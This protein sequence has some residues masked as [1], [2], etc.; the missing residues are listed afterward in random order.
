MATTYTVK[1]GDTLSEIAVRYGTTVSKLVELNNINDPDFIVIG[2]VLKLTGTASPVATNTTSK[3]TL[4][5]FGLQSNTDRTVY[6]TWT[7]SK[8]N[9]ENY[10]V[11]WHY[12][13][14]D[15]V[16]FVGDDSTTEYKQ[17]TY[18]APANAIMVKFKVKAISKKHKVNGKETSYWT[19]GWS[20]EKSYTFNDETPDKPSTPTVKLDKFKLTA[21]IANLDTK[22]TRVQFQI[23]KNNQT[24]FK[25]GA[26][27]VKTRYA[28]YSCTVDAGAEYKVRCRSYGGTAA[29]EWSDY[30]NNVSTIPSAPSSITTCRASSETSVYLEWG[31]VATA[32]SYAIEYTTK[33]EYFDS[34]D[35]T[36]KEEN[37]EFTHYELTGLETGEEYFFR[38]RAANSVGASAWSGIVSVTIGEEPAAPTTWSSTTTA[39]IGEPLNLYWVHNTED[40]SS[41][42]YAEISLTINGTNAVYT[43]KNSTG[44]NEKDKT[45]CCSI[46]TDT[47]EYSYV[48]DGNTIT[49]PL[50]VVAAGDFVEGVTIQWKVRTAG[51][52]KVYGE[53]SI[54]RTV[55]IYAPPTL[56]L[57]ITDSNGDE[58]TTLSSFP[59]CIRALAGPNTQAPVGYH[60]IVTSND[61]YE[62]VDQI[63]NTRMISQGEQIYSKYFDISEVLR[64][65]LSASNLDLENNMSYTVTCT[66][67]MNSGLTAE[68]TG[69]FDV[70]WR[71]LEYEPN[72]EISI[73]EDTLVAHIA[74]YCED[75]LAGITLS[76]YRREFDGAFTEIATGIKNGSYTFVTD[77]HPA[78]DYARYRVVATDESTG[79]VSYYDLPGY[80]IG[81]KAAIIQWEEEWSSFDTSEENELEEPAWSGSMLKLPYNIDVSDSRNVDVALVEYI[82]RAHPISYYGTQLGETSN[83]SMEIPKDDKETLYALRRLSIWKGDVYVREPSGSGYWANISVS[84]SQKH[85]EVTI[86][87][88]LSIKRVEG[89]M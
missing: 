11:M 63:G 48:V 55:D 56:E 68:G 70:S 19:G 85:C 15:N 17:S 84:F 53:W 24:V 83:W 79:A 16:W 59:I 43:I 64:V 3:P 20:S 32:T 49:K 25:T 14:G 2:Q 41:Q 8:S 46:N 27:N 51:V 73:D 76:V 9:T 50:T 18:T 77:P 81:E 29:S 47:A 60:L 33:K 61:A 6:A 23:V 86:P 67:A 52:T 30:S 26:A 69:E 7:W 58:L 74:P 34:S 35:N 10:Q 66:V 89:G 75:E 4:G 39:I 72:A 65:E 54:E 78:L 38:V 44:V 80:P 45:S 57:N 37:I 28:S 62:T 31:A 40:G 12:H 1:K 21:E 42:T 5:V 36:S 71:D 88:T 22:A 13:T 82:G 87:V